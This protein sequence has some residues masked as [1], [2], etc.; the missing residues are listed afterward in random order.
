MDIYHNSVEGIVKQI[1]AARK[2]KM[3]G[4]VLFSFND[5]PERAPLVAALAAS[6]TTRMQVGQ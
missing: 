5:L 6:P 3:A 4:F 2:S 1:A